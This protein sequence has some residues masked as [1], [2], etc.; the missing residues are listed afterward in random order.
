MVP[1]LSADHERA[2]NRRRRIIV[3]YDAMGSELT[4]LK[5]DV[6]EW[7]ACGFRYIDQPGSQV[8]S[9]WWDCAHGNDAI[10]PSKVL[11]PER[12]PRVQ[13][14]REK[15]VDWIAIFLEQTRRR[16]ME[17]FWHHRISEVEVGPKGLEMEHVNPVKKE[18]PDW[19]IKTWWWQGMWNLAVAGVRE[20]K[21]QILRELAERY[22]FDGFQIDFARHVPVLPVGRQWELREHV[23]EFM[24]MVRRMLLE[25]AAKK[26]RPILL[27]AKVPRNSAECRCDGFDVQAW[28]REGLVDMLTLGSRSFDVDVEGFR[29]ASG[30]A[31]KLYPCIDDHHAS[32]GYRFPPIEVFRGVVCNW[33]Q[34]G[35][36]GVVTFNWHAA[37]REVY[38]SRG[39]HP[40]PESHE[41][42]Y[43]EIGSPATLEG[44]AK[45]FPV[46]RRGGY[47]WSEGAF[48][49]NAAAQLPTALRYDGHPST[50]EL[51]C[52]ERPG[53]A[54]LHITVSNAVQGDRVE[55]EMNGARLDGSAYDYAW[56]DPQIIAP[57][58]PLW[59]SGGTGEYSVNP[60][61]KLLRAMYPVAP[62]IVRT[63]VNVVKTSVAR[64]MPH[65][66]RQLYVEKVELHA[67]H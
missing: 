7:L 24:R 10:Y 11:P 13:A 63:G 34:Q 53:P 31:V 27:A 67:T 38:T 15:G 14:W 25:V 50:I 2:V 36:D 54:A 29:Q 32:D 61:Q 44:K 56:K 33:F 16:G 1:Q 57:N 58:Q 39:L 20:F 4:P 51:R 60:K 42:A 46:E 9:I 3:Q 59:A 41:T 17:V 19:V 64:Q 22:D 43:R 28:G 40:G 30:P 26:G 55:V 12:D 35:A 21:L 49:Q 8:D 48:N 47:P 23:T 65:C 52:G 37:P 45:V 62:A 66:C 5:M 6:D 18:H